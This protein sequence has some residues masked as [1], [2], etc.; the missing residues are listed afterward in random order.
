MLVRA[1]KMGYYNHKRI[2][3]FVL[4]TV[5]GFTQ[6]AF[7]RVLTAKEF[8]PEEQFSAAWMEKVDENEE[9][10]QKKEITKR[11]QALRTN[12]EVI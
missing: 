3:E 12:E 7:G 6:D 10:P 2:R 11:R 5:K 1:K 8:T 4:K 9:I